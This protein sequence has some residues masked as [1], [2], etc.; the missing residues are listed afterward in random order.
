MNSYEDKI[1][2]EIAAWQ[3]EMTRKPN[4]ANRFTKNIQTRIH[5]ALPPKAT[6]LITAAIKNMVRAVLLGSE[7]IT[8]PPRQGLS[9]EQRDTIAQERVIFYKRTATLEGAGTGAGG[10]LLGLADF[11]LLLSIKMRFL[12]DVA[13]VYGYDVRDLQERMYILHLFQLAFSSRQKRTIV[14]QKIMDWEE[15]SANNPQTIEGIDWQL[16]QQEYRDYL[17]IAKLLQY[18]PVI[19]AVFGAYANYKL[20]NELGRTAMNAYRLRYLKNKRV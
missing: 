10:I 20:L 17:D 8:D 12:F 14:Y 15:Y 19:G 18:I 6:V 9:L 1:L 3:K 16:F 11:P 4:L 13:G 5:N 2:Q 7:I